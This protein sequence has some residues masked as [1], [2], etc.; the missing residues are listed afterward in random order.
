MKKTKL[1]KSLLVAAGLCVGASAW[2]EDVYETVYTRATVGAWTTDDIADWGNSSDATINATHGLY[3]EL[4]NPNHAYSATK[5]FAIEENAKIKYEVSWYT[6]N[7]TGRDSNYEYIKFGDKVC[8]GYNSNYHFYL[9]LTGTC[10]MTEDLTAQLKTPGSSAITIIFDTSKKKVE[11]FIFRGTDITNKVADAL[12]GNFNSLTFGFQRGGSTSNWAY[13]NGL[14]TITV[15][16]CKQD[17]INANFTINYKFGDAIVK[18]VSSSSV[19]DDVITA[20][21]AVDGEGDYAGNHYLITAD[22][23]PSMTLVA[24]ENILNVPVRAPYTATLAV[25][26]TIN[27][28]ANVDNIALVE[29]DNKSCAWSYPYSKY[30]K[31]GDTYYLCD[32]TTFVHSGT[33]ADGET[34]TQSVSYSTAD[35]NIVYYREAESVSGNDPNCSWGGGGHVDA[36]N[37]RDRGISVGTLSAG[38]YLF[39]V[40]ILGNNRRQVVIRQSTSDPLASVGTSNEDHSTGV[41]SSLF[42]LTEE[43]SNLW[44][45]GANSGEA[46]T[47]Q[48]EDFDYVL[49]KKINSMSIVGDFSENGWTT[50][51]GIVM[52]QS[53]ENPAVWTAVVDNF[54]VTSAKYDYQYKAIANGNWTDWVI[55]NDNASNTDKNQEYNFNYDGAR[56]GK[57]TLTFTANTQAKTVELSIEKQP[58]ATIYFVNTG[59]WAAENIKAWVWDANNSNY[60]YTGG[61]WPGQTMTAIGEQIDG[62]DVYSWSTYVLNPTP[63][64]LIIS[65]NGSDTE[66]TGDQ[67]FV[68]GATYRPDGGIASVT[69]TITAAGY[70]T[71][72]SANALDF[73]STGLTAYIAKKDAS[74]N[75]TFTPV[76]KVPANTGVLLKGDAGNYT[77][78]TTSDATDDVTDNVLV[79]VTV[80]T[81]VPAGSFVLMNGEK[82]VGFY[83]AANEFTVGANT[84]YI[85]ALPQQARMFIAIN[86]DDVTTGTQGIEGVAT[87]KMNTG[88]IYNLQGQRVTKAAKGLYIING[89]KMVIK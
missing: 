54:V 78:S 19:V 70:A 45:N 49:I 77:I 16:Q 53:T 55:G 10:A 14:E 74:N 5:T 72:C 71:F 50:E 87:V 62:K 21:M 22:E 11:S 8:I 26:T 84:A 82:G 7:S 44:V 63:T 4:T 25:T 89:K 3:F 39:T 68:N 37:A 35:E 57:Y 56:E 66:R 17:V 83:K 86:F 61:T 65:N 43:T 80:D 48:S 36:Q 47:N 1:F 33:F 60:N 23:A 30:V 24:G 76:M 6:G 79:G 15:S 73:S 34:I 31:S 28:N 18:T 38:T 13:P 42:M 12:D 29:S 20:D 41:K 9:S 52:T 51:S 2:A 75:V 32:A 85:E 69:K 46:K 88:E 58:T 64:T 67:P 81:P 27:G 40:N 59:D